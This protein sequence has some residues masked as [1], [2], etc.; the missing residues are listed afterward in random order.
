M[1][2]SQIQAANDWC[3]AI[4]TY[5]STITP[6]SATAVAARLAM[7]NILQGI[8]GDNGVTILANAITA[9]ATTLASGM[10]P[11]FVG[12]P[13]AAPLSPIL[14]GIVTAGINGSDEW[15]DQANSF[16]TSIDGW[17][18]TGTAT[19]SSSGAVVPWS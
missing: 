17:F 10:A 15:S 16:A 7:F 14:N 3:D 9:Y 19:N 5:A 8:S 11:A 12:A 18:R 2:P 1:S 4:N 13:P 6:P